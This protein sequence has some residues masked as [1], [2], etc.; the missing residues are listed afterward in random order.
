MLIDTLEAVPG[1]GDVIFSTAAKC[2]VYSRKGVL[3]KKDTMVFY[4]VCPEGYGDGFWVK[5]NS[6]EIKYEQ[7]NKD[8]RYSF[9]VYQKRKDGSFIPAQKKYKNAGIIKEAN[10]R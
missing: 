6:F 4:I 1:C 9:I 2:M 8:K 7:F 10:K 3:N 5:G